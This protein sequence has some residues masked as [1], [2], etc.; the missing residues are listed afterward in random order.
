VRVGHCL[1]SHIKKYSP[2]I[3]PVHFIFHRCRTTIVTP[4]AT[5][6]S[7]KRK[8]YTC[9]K[10]AKTSKGLKRGQCSTTAAAL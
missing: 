5:N 6:A 10:C 9:S 4:A 8:T 2:E 7:Q 3:M 1:E